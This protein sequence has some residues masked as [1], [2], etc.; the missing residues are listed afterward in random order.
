MSMAVTQEVIITCATDSSINVYSVV[1]ESNVALLKGHDSVVRG[2]QVDAARNRVVSSGDD[3]MC[4]VYD[5]TNALA[6]NRETKIRAY[7]KP[8]YCLKG[9][10]GAIT[11]MVLQ[12]DASGQ[13]WLRVAAICNDKTSHYWTMK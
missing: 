5:F 11:D 12:H 3:K 4:A 13:K 10:K 6:Q 2:V 1:T 7:V 8:L 9:P